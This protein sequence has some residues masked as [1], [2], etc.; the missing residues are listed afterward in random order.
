VFLFCLLPAAGSAQDPPPVPPSTPQPPP[1]QPAEQPEPE[2]ADP[3]V[4]VD[5]LQPDFNLAALPTTLR[6]PVGKWAFRVTHRFTRSLAEGDFGDAASNLFGL[7]GGS[8]VGLEIRFGL[9][10]GTQIGVHRTSDRSI[11]LFGQQNVMN[12]RDGRPFGLDALATL[13]GEDNLS[14]RYK[15]AL[16]V[17]ASKNFGGVAALYVEPLVVLNTNPFETG[18]AH[19]A[20]IGLGGRFRVRPSMYLMAEYT[21]RVAGYRPSVDQITFA[22]ES[23]AGGHLFQINVGNGFGTTLGQVAGGGIEYDQWY[24]GFNISRKFFR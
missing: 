12:E 5:P 21:P 18:D 6:M 17:I 24:L 19:T 7:D 8:Q 11:Q 4:R 20:M 3:D 1:T 2:R 23:R 13:E 14:E 16:G 10:P 15:S 22:V 9:L